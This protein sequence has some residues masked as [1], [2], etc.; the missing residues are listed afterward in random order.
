MTY[1]ITRWVG[2]LTSHSSQVNENFIQ[3]ILNDFCIFTLYREVRV[4]GISAFSELVGTIEQKAFCAV[5]G[6]PRK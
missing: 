3:I 1:S 6:P 4:L 2:L 5:D